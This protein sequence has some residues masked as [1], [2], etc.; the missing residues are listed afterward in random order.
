[1]I[2][3]YIKIIHAFPQTGA[4]A[5]KGIVSFKWEINYVGSSRPAS[6]YIIESDEEPEGRKFN[7]YLVSNIIKTT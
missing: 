7:L 5:F 3:C 4:H 6:Q 1:M 2:N